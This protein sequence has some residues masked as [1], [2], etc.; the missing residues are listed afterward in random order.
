MKKEF[1]YEY[2]EDGVVIDRITV[3]SADEL[4][5]CIGILR[6]WEEKKGSPL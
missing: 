4:I 6:E 5:K 3:D 2:L 1:R